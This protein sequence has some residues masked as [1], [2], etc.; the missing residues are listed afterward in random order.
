VA[1]FVIEF[2]IDSRKKWHVVERVK[3]KEQAEKNLVE[4]KKHIRR[5]DEH[6]GMEYR[7]YKAKG[8]V[9]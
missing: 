8:N 6:N 9:C 2:K 3:T 4:Y 5:E 1:H 7:M